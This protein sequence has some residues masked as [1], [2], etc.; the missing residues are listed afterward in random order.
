MMH[1]PWHGRTGLSSISSDASWPRKQIK[2][3]KHLL[4]GIQKEHIFAS[5]CRH[6]LTIKVS[7][8]IRQNKRES[9]VWDSTM[10]KW[11]YKCIM[12]NQMHLLQWVRK[13]Q[14]TL[15]NRYPLCPFTTIDWSDRNQIICARWNELLKSGVLVSLSCGRFSDQQPKPPPQRSFLICA[16]SNH[17]RHCLSRN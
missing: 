8:S 7:R 11:L 12:L 1:A 3:E 9:R 14:Y 4:L 17:S 16:T 6:S 10:F 13:V 2:N 15:Q 5:K